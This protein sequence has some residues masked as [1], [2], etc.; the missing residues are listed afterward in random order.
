MNNKQRIDEILNYWTDISKENPNIDFGSGE[1]Y[2]SIYDKLIFTGVENNEKNLEYDAQYKQKVDPLVGN[3]IFYNFIDYY[4]NNPNISV[5]CNP[6]WKYFCQFKTRDNQ[7]RGAS[8]HIK[9]YVPLDA[10][11]IEAGSKMIFDYIAQN[12]ICSISKISS[13]IRF[14]DLVIRIVEP[15]QLYKIIDFIDNN[16]YIQE[17][18]ISPNPFAFNYHNIA[19]ACDGSLSYN[20]VISGLIDL[21]TAYIQKNKYETIPNSDDFY[22]YISFLYMAEFKFGTRNTIEDYFAKIDDRIINKN[23]YEQVIRLVLE[24]SDSMYNVNDFIRHYKDCSYRELTLEDT[25]DLLGDAIY[26][27]SEKISRQTGRSLKDSE[28]LA[29]QQIALYLNTNN[30]NCITRDSNL[31]NKIHNSNFRDNL[32]YMLMSNEQNLWQFVRDLE[33]GLDNT[34]KMFY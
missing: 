19:L 33:V 11:H 4:A 23:N 20:G 14:D 16:D 24:S 18:L 8:Q 13:Q 27:I 10:E 17:G 2:G 26:I 34:R 28:N 7:I 3:P 32:N 21:Y 25:I 29:I 5:F 22:K 12:K 15:D 6:N 9:I 30:Q 31:R 1:I